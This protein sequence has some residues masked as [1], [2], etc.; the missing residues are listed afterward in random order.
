MNPL[1]K[2]TFDSELVDMLMTYHFAK[3]TEPGILSWLRMTKLA[4][5]VEI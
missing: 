1:E 4:L 3:Q 2:L 5:D